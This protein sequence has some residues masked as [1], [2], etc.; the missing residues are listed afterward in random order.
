LWGLTSSYISIAKTVLSE[1]SDASNRTRA[2]TA[3][4]LGNILGRL[5]GYMIGGVLADPADKYPWLK[6]RF[7]NENPYALPVFVAAGFNLFSSLLAFC[8][9]PETK[10]KKKKVTLQGTNDIPLLDQESD[11]PPRKSLVRVLR[12]K[13]VVCTVFPVILT[14]CAHAVFNVIFPLWVLLPAADRG[15]DFGSSEIGMSR[16]IAVPTDMLVQFVAYP[17]F[18]RKFGLLWSYRVG[19]IFWVLTIVATPFASYAKKAKVDQIWLMIWFVVVCNHTWSCVVLWTGGI[20]SA[21]SAE[22]W[23]RVRIVKIRQSLIGVGGVFGSVIGG[24]FFSWGAQSETRSGIFRKFPFN[25][26][27]V[28]V[29]MAVLI[30]FLTIASSCLPER[31]EFTPEEWRQR[32]EWRRINSKRSVSVSMDES[33][34]STNKYKTSNADRLS[35]NSWQG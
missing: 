12:T 17:W 33:Y 35:V 22:A 10:S 15:F 29:C 30:F 26:F 20:M 21:N 32:E 4:G 2:F 7:L 27:F 24:M 25:F 28:W 16:V 19:T 9:L 31:I 13:A 6:T 18:V 1:V 23:Y 11:I 5:L 34:Y 14:T 3:F 8:F